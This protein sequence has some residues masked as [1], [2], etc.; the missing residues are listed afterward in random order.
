MEKK[1]IPSA[2]Y[3]INRDRVWE[4]SRINCFHRGCGS[5]GALVTSLA[6][7]EDARVQQNKW[8]SGFPSHQSLKKEKKKKR[9]QQK[10]QILTYLLSFFSGGDFLSQPWKRISPPLMSAARFLAVRCA[11]AARLS[12]EH[13]GWAV[14]RAVSVRAALPQS[15]ASIGSK[16][17]W[18][19]AL[20]LPDT[21]THTPATSVRND[22][23][24][25]ICP[26]GEKKGEGKKNNAKRDP[27]AARTF[28]I[29]SNRAGKL[30]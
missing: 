28:E 6:Q 4:L 30:S 26:T 19:G 14:Q 9:T 3:F 8:K 5:R 21:H 10:S 13:D 2:N 23:S 16:P 15:A 24:Q 25:K 7:T 22:S 12:L 27:S 29:R 11:G 1:K 20:M 18:C 17:K